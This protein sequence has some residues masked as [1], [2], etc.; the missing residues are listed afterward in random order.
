MRPRARIL[1]AAALAL[2]GSGC[3][4]WRNLTEAPKPDTVDLALTVKDAWTGEPLPWARCTLDGSRADADAEGKIVFAAVPTGRKSLA[5]SCESYHGRAVKVDAGPGAGRLELAMVRKGFG[6]WYPEDPVRQLRIDQ[7]GGNYRFPGELVIQASPGDAGRIFHYAWTSTRHGTLPS[8]R[9]LR[10]ATEAL[11]QDSVEFTL[12][13]TVHAELADTLIEV[14]K[15]ELAIFL[16]RN[17]QPS[18]A[19]TYTFQ[20]KRVGTGCDEAYVTFIYAASD[21]DGDCSVRFTAL[22]PQDSPLGDLDTLLACSDSTTAT[23]TLA[24]HDG[25]PDWSRPRSGD[26]RI[27]VEDDNGGRRETTLK[28]ATYSNLHPM[29]SLEQI[30]PQQENRALDTL[31]FR[32]VARDRDAKLTTLTVDWKDGTAPKQY[33]FAYLQRNDSLDLIL[34]H[35][36]ARA[37]SYD[38]EAT[39]TDGCKVTVKDTLRI[40]VEDR[41]FTGAPH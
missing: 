35:S 29:V 13:L 23:F 5:C 14:G 11:D 39:A 38:V 6:E 10:I 8:T 3:D 20:P 27:R 25:L 19:V 18:L 40:L 34:P 30:D 41:A 9:T 4:F 1:G 36:F 28:V 2:L 32:L 33:P 37:G 7:V 16:T 24:S 15:S 31:R 17:Q 26:V 22:E 12:S 21:P